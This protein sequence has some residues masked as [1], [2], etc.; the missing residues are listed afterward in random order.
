MIL[1]AGPCVIESYAILEKTLNKILEAIDG[2]EIELFFKSSVL[3]D[4]RTKTNNFR[5]V[6]P[7]SFF[8]GLRYLRDLG[9]EYKIKICTDFHEI[10]QIQECGKFVDMIQIPAFLGRQVSLLEAAAKTKKVIHLKKPQ[11]MSPQDIKIPVEI[12]KNANAKRII[13]TDRGTSFGYNDVM[14]DPRHIP[15]MKE[16]NE[17]ILVDITHMNKNYPSWYWRKL[18]FVKAL[19]MSAIVS[20]ANGLFMEVHPDLDK[21]LC[22]KDTMITT[23]EF[24]KLIKTFYYVMEK[25]KE[26]H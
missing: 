2:L 6:D 11:F 8:L 1:I 9:K 5:S 3:K 19:G 4:N 12:L 18:D 26:Y 17:E 15:I 10:N 14:F 7:N 13:V 23:K 24:K 21:A 16:V 22:D 25:V 20:G